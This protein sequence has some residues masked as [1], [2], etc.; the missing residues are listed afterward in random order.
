[1]ANAGQ[2]PASMHRIDVL[3]RKLHKLSKRVDARGPQLQ[4]I[5]KRV[6]ASRPLLIKGRYCE[7]PH[8]P[9][10][11]VLLPPAAACA[12]REFSSIF[13]KAK[14]ADPFHVPALADCADFCSSAP[15]LSRTRGECT[16]PSWT[17]GEPS[18]IAKPG[19]G[20]WAFLELQRSD[21][22]SAT[23]ARNKETGPRRLTSHARPY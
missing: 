13:S 8:H 7:V 1:M 6:V 19:F 15:S 2:G 9:I 4:D 21:T 14:L 5:T 18:P 10:Y 17:T 3:T 16:S 20:G 11:L 22:S 12:W 23:A